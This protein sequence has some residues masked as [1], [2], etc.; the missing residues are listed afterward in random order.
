MKG[1]KVKQALTLGFVK[2]WLYNQGSDFL[3]FSDQ[4][5][6]ELSLQGLECWVFTGLP[7][8]VLHWLRVVLKAVNIFPSLCTPG[9]LSLM[10]VCAEKLS[11][12]GESLES[13]KPHSCIQSQMRQGMGVV[14]ALGSKIVGSKHGLQNGFWKSYPPACVPFKVLD[15][16]REE[17]ACG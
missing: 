2:S 16:F 10:C 11:D 12:F 6:S 3:G 9:L 15:V 13:R 4:A 8:L 1:T 7:T 14:S 5:N 17:P